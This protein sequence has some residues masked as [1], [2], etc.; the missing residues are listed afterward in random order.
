ME[1]WQKDV[2]KSNLAELIQDTECNLLLIAKFLAQ[3]IINHEEKQKI[4]SYLKHY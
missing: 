1:N 4:V 2:I 3:N